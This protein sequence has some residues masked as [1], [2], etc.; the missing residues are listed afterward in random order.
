MPGIFLG[1]FI[2]ILGGGLTYFMP[3]REVYLRKEEDGFSI[4]WKATRFEN[5][6]KEEYE[7]IING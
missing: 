5:F 3:P 1:F 6:Y 4:S 7:R 2:I